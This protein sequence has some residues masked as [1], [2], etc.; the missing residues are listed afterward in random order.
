MSFQQVSLHLCFH[1]TIV[2]TRYAVIQGLFSYKIVISYPMQ[3]LNV[4]K[5][6]IFFWTG[7]NKK[8]DGDEKVGNMST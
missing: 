2:N 3:Y 1:T 8:A 5:C 6:Q 7:L 4:Y